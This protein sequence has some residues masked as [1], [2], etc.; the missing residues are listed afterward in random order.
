MNVNLTSTLPVRIRLYFHRPKTIQSQ[1]RNW[2]LVFVPHTE[3]T[4]AVSI[5]Q[6]TPTQSRAPQQWRGHQ[7]I[8]STPI[9]T[10]AV[11]SPMKLP[12]LVLDK[13]AGDPLAWPEFLAT[14]YRAGV[15]DSVKMNYFK[16][17]V[18]GRAK[19]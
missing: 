16:T 11:M 6:K 8:S 17:L 10:P 9:N 13:L 19:S 18:T 4:T 12:K 5:P 1:K 7:A 3:L 14:V 15:P 2:R